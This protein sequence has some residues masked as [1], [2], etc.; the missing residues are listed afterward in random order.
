MISC[1]SVCD[2]SFWWWNCSTEADSWIL[3]I[4]ATNNSPCTIASHTF[5]VVESSWNVMAHGDTWEGKWRGNWQME[6]VA[7]TAHTTSE[8]G[9]SSITV[10]TADV[11]TLAASSQRNWCPHQFKWTRPF[12]RKTKS[13][14]CMCAI[15]FQMQSTCGYHCLSTKYGRS[16]Q[17]DYSRA[18]PPF[19]MDIN[20]TAI[21]LPNNVG[22]WVWN[23]CMIGIHHVVL[24][25]LI[26]LDHR[27]WLRWIWKDW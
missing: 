15:T 17:S 13:G 26:T 10:T 1:S 27:L 9:A 14:F 19:M 18:K 16:L 20:L 12:R 24:H 21:K 23:N 22:I 11:H 25:M 4:Y 2:V 3:L 5:H 8:H 6:W 7:S